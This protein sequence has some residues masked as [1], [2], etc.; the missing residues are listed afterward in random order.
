VAGRASPGTVTRPS[1]TIQVDAVDGSEPPAPVD[2]THARLLLEDLEEGVIVQDRA[3][4]VITVNPAASRILGW[5]SDLI[6]GRGPLEPQWRWPVT[7]EDGS[8]LPDGERPA[9]VALLTG[10]PQVASNLRVERGDG[11]FVW[12]SVTARPVFEAGDAQPSGVVVSFVDITQQRVIEA[13]LRERERDAERLR[14]QHERVELVA[15]LAEAE[16]LESLGRLARGIAHD[17]KNLL[18]VILNHAA[19]LTDRV[20]PDPTA[21]VDV[22]RIRQA[23]ESGVEVVN[24]LLSASDRRTDVVET[25]DVDD[26]VDLVVGLLRGPFA[27]VSICWARSEQPAP[28]TA[29]QVPFEQAV[30]NLLLNARDALGGRG[31]ITVDVARRDDPASPSGA[32]VTVDVR[33]DGPGMPI[34]VVDRAFESGFTTKPAGLGIGLASVE[35]TVTDAGGHVTLDSHLGA[36]TTVRVVLPAA[37]RDS[38]G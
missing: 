3:N 21:G 22:D 17:F 27:P 29:E 20:A 24:W 19:A 13:T 1:R 31:T 15:R 33:D 12:V 28:V 35:Q 6:A 23:A 14:A 16:R 10:E 36:G 9:V 18:G 32:W 7:R 38:T 30:L 26:A 25:F 37:A 4:R 34:E 5:P 11:S 8:P 2:E